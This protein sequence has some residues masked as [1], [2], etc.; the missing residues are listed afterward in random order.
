MIEI[1][2]ECLDT[3]I[4][5]RANTQKKLDLKQDLQAKFDKS[6][7]LKEYLKS[8]AWVEINRPMLERTL[9][10]GMRT[11]LRDGLTMN[12]SQLK[13]IISEMRANLNNMMEIKFLI[14]QGEQAAKKLESLK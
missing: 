4:N 6:I 7:S 1:I 11:I 14:E 12:E 13:T 8:K 5:P 10:G 9:E 2:R 3:I